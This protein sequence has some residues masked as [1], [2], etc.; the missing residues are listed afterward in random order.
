MP[1]VRVDDATDTRLDEYRDLTDAELRRAREAFGADHGI[2]IAEG[3]LVLRQLLRS[4]LRIRSVLLTA[5]RLAD[6]DGSLDDL[7]VP[8]FVADQQVLNDV[9]GFNIHR[10][11]LACADRPAPQ[12]WEE[13]VASARRLVLLEDVND[14]ENLGALFRNAAGLGM[15]AVLLSP[16]CADPLYRRTVRVSLGHVL[17]VPFARVE[18]WPQA[19]DVLAGRFRLVALTP[20]GDV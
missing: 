13:V 12:A 8:V 11:V 19:L 1:V 15:D 18:P 6:F 2:F 10:G 3:A 17:H 20:A 9:G 4:R 14:Q 7:P 5:R 16:R